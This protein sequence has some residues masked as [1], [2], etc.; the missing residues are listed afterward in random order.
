MTGM[1]DAVAELI[2]DLALVSPAQWLLRALGL[3]GTLGAL[4]CAFPAG[5]FHGLAPT[6][7]SLLVLLL[8]LVMAVAPDSDL[9]TG[10]PIV[11]VAGA[12][13]GT[14]PSWGRMVGTGLFLLLTHM[15]WAF[16]A[17]TPAHGRVSRGAALLMLRTVAVAVAAS[18]VA[19][20][21]VWLVTRLSL[22]GWAVPLGAAAL[23]AC[24]VALTPLDR[25]TG[26]ST[27]TSRRP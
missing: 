26:S 27:A 18:L 10:M 22:G 5:M 25:S 24:F 17:V 1:I 11:L 2:A 9:G 14:E 8:A 7:A 12:S 19:L 4:W 16:A 20:G 3:L 6:L 23:I 21:L 13:L 15:A